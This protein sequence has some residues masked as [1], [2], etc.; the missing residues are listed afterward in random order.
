MHVKIDLRNLKKKTKQEHCWL[1]SF[2]FKHLK[3]VYIY[4][5][6]FVSKGKSS[7]ENIVPWIF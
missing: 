5:L 4:V 7:L 1:D 6:L 3:F 2:C